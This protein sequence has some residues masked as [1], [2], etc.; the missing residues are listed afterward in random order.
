MRKIKITLSPS[1]SDELFQK[2]CNGFK[3]QYPEELSFIRANDTQMIGGFIA[4]V[5]G[6]IIDVSLNAQLARMKDHLKK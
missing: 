6:E 2:I 3:R 5:E 1:C 4:D